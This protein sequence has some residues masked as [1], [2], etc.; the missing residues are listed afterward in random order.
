MFN[1]SE[2]MLE[3]QNVIFDQNKTLS[4]QVS[5]SYPSGALRRSALAERS[6][7]PERSDG[8]ERSGGALRRSAPMVRS[9]PTTFI[10]LIT[11]I[12]LVAIINITLLFQL[13]FVVFKCH[14]Y[15]YCLHALPLRKKPFT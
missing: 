12:T 15:K 2:L 7:S 4:C 10:T 14:L 9:A 13:R 6:D 8:V 11:L 5:V 3:I 1:R